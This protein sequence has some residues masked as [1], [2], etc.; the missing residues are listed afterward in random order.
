MLGTRITVN[1]A[2]R[3]WL[4][5]QVRSTCEAG[6]TLGREIGQ[7]VIDRAKQDGAN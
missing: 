4:G 1:A 6:L 5:I 7:A 2:S 3:L